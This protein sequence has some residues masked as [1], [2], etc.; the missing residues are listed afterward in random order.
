MRGGGGEGGRY[1]THQI[2]NKYNDVTND[3]LFHNPVIFELEVIFI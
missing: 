2:R 1:L 3:Y